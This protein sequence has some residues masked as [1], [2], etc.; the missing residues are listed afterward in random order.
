MIVHGDAALLSG[1][2][3]KGNTIPT[4]QEAVMSRAETAAIDPPC[5]R[6]GNGIPRGKVPSSHL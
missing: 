5:H 4:P 3:I 6:M 2:G 1:E